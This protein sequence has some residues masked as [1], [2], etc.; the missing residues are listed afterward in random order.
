MAEG[1]EA[2]GA[3]VGGLVSGGHETGKDATVGNLP[4]GPVGE[5]VEGS[6][7]GDIGGDGGDG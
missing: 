1:G 7:G 6:A 3:E 5:E 2:S 4:A